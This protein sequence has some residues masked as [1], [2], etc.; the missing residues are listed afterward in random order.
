GQSAYAAANVFLDALAAHRH[1]RGLPA[2]S[3][4]YALWQT[5]TGLSQWLTDVDLQRMR[6][7]G[8]PPLT[9]Q[10]GL[11]DL[12]AAVAA[13]RPAVLSMHVDLPAL[14]RLPELPHP[15]LRA[16]VPAPR[17]ARP[18][19][20]PVRDEALRRRL[21]ESSGPEQLAELRRLVVATV[22]TVLGF[23]DEADVDP[24]RGFLES[25][26]DSLAAI[27]LRNQLNKALGLQLPAMAVFDGQNP[28]QLAALVQAEL[29]AAGPVTAPATTV[30][31]ITGVVGADG[32]DGVE[33]GARVGARTGEA[34]E[35]AAGTV[36]APEPA[37]DADSL[38]G[39][40][41]EAVL[42]GKVGKAFGLLRSVAELRD[43]FD[44]E[45]MTTPLASARLGDGPGSP[46]IVCVSTPMAGGG[47]H[48]HARL[49]SHLRGAR[50]VSA[51]ALPGFATGEPLPA[52]AEAVVRTMAD[53]VLDS[54]PDRPFVLL[55]YSS[56]G[57]IAYATAYHLEQV[58]GVVPAGVVLLDSYRVQDEAMVVGMERLARSL[59]EVEQTVGRY[60]STRLSAMSRYFDI[61]PDFKLDAVSAP[62]LFVSA[63]GDFLDRGQYEGDPGDLRARP[64]DPDHELRA[65]PGSHF[66]L[67]QDDAGTTAGVV[68]DWVGQL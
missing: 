41:R 11:A 48:Q 21:R 66:T 4:A 23:D 13:G 8:M 50:P 58:H 7:T 18:G 62:V 24:R 14:R 9:E 20:G 22:A 56:G 6:R 52:S 16:L 57:L 26:F 31:A 67:I 12:D 61:L 34:S 47:L 27:D 60:D 55:G 28:E 44:T 32:G 42:A 17:A 36:G 38:S 35:A 54:A 2:T 45:G 3:I 46:R 39:L 49:A 10:E 63:T 59:L 29:A 19:G 65:A 25:G 43:S 40:F 30:T 1:A 68:E 5:E 37:G 53:N 33:S 64:W 15:M 51:L